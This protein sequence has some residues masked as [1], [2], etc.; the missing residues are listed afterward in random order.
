MKSEVVILT[1]AVLVLFDVI[2]VRKALALG[3]KNKE[4][5]K[6]REGFLKLGDLL[7]GKRILQK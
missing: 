6:K 1:I 2:R 4:T 7:L 3:L 5:H